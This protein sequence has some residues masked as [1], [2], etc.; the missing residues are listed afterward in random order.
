MIGRCIAAAGGA[1]EPVSL[2]KLELLVAGVQERGSVWQGHRT[3]AR[4]HVVVE[5]GFVQIEREPGRAPVLTQ[6]ME[7]MKPTPGFR[8]WAKVKARSAPSPMRS[9]W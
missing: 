4:A 9:P 7:A 8:V 3:L 1:A 2:A 6:P 5:G